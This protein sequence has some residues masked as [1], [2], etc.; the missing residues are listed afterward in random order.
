MQVGMKMTAA[1]R[2]G[3]FDIDRMRRQVDIWNEWKAS[4]KEEDPTPAMGD[5]KPG[6]AGGSSEPM[7]TTSPKGD[8]LEAKKVKATEASKEGT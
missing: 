2:S 8:D 3:K 1:D 7:T 4:K 5:E 6:G